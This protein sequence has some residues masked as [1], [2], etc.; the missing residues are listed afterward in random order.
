[1]KPFFGEGRNKIKK[2]VLHNWTEAIFFI[3]NFISF[4]SLDCFT[5][6]FVW[7]FNK[8]K[9]ILDYIFLVFNIE[10]M[11]VAK[12]IDRLKIFLG[13]NEHPHKAV[14][15]APKSIKQKLPNIIPM[16]CSCCCCWEKFK[17]SLSFRSTRKC[18]KSGFDMYLYYNM[19]NKKAG[20]KAITILMWSALGG[21]L[22]NFHFI[23]ESIHK[24]WNFEA[25]HGCI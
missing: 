4:S 6:Y 21:R 2:H 3:A 10:R 23:V 8:K 14:I 7:L 20:N 19:L 16:C 12:K 1:M 9:M 5:F 24:K 22:Q 11:V 18:C 17:Y 25:S 15:N 13:N